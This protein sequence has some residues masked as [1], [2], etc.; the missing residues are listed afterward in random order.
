L[1]TAF[2]PEIGWVA[3]DD[4]GACA[5]TATDTSLAV[6][7]RH[8]QDIEEPEGWPSD[9]DLP[10]VLVRVVVVFAESPGGAAVEFEGSLLCQSGHLTVG[11]AENERVL[12][13]PPGVL[14]VQVSLFP[15]EF[16]EYV[17]LRLIAAD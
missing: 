17:V 16:A 14:R 2:D 12:D 6:Q 3:P 15:R 9:L 8:C 13:V 10:E 11:D 4:V 7:V 1:L 5:V